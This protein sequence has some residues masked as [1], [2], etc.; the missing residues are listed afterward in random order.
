VPYGDREI[1]SRE[2]GE[3]SLRTSHIYEA[4]ACTAS[5]QRWNMVRFS[6]IYVQYRYTGTVSSVTRL[7]FLVGS[8]QTKGKEVE[9]GLEL[10]CRWKVLAAAERSWIA[11]E[12]RKG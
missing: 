6:L 1:D 12:V 10:R 5:G 4:A 7:S 11:D 3:E 8:K 9:V 2:G